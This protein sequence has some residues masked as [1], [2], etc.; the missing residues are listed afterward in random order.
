MP[1]S[2]ETLSNYW[3]LICIIKKI[4]KIC[5]ILC[6]SK[7][8]SWYLCGTLCFSLKILC[9]FSQTQSGQDS[10]LDF[11]FLYYSVSPQ[12]SK[13]CHQLPSGS[14]PKPRSHPWFLPVLLSLHPIHPEVLRALIYNTLSNVRFSLLHC[15]LTRL[16]SKLVSDLSLSPSTIYSLCSSQ[17]TT[18]KI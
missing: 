11:P 6:C 1:F 18:L 10:G 14:H 12:L 9:S 7:M 4:F 3:L 8:M 15:Y 13:W 2:W 17:S 5:I 16:A